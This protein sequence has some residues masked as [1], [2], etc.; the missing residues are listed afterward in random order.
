MEVLY[1]SSITGKKK[2]DSTPASFYTDVAK[3][4]AAEEHGKGTVRIEIPDGYVVYSVGI[5]S[6][7]QVVNE[8]EN[9]LPALYNQGYGEK[10]LTCIIPEKNS[11][12]FYHMTPKGN[13]FVASYGCMGTEKGQLFGERSYVYPISVFWAKYFEKIGKGYVDDSDVYLQSQFANKDNIPLGSRTGHPETASGRLYALLMQLAQN[14]VRNAKVQVPVTAEIISA[15]KRYLEQMRNSGTVEEFNTT[16]LRL[17]AVLQRPVPT[18]DGTG[19][20]KALAKGGSDFPRIIE[21][22]EDL[23]TAMEGTLGAGIS[24]PIGD[25]SDFGIEVYDATEKQKAEALRTL[26]P[27][28]RPKVKNVYRVIPAEQ[29]KLFN[30]Y[31][32]ENGISRVKQL[33]HGSRN[34]NWMSIIRNSLM[35]NQNAVI[36]AKMFGK[37]IYFAPSSMK[38]WGYTSNGK[39]TGLK[40]DVSI[41]GLYAVAYGRQYDVSA[42]RENVDWKR[43]MESRGCS[44]LHAHAGRNLRA[45]EIVV[46]DEAAVVLNYIVEFKC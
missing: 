45:D 28:L 37:G 20:K 22:E 21:R 26:N 25:F 33:W 6:G 9:T 4:I 2:F 44:S 32:K 11:Y 16:L 15:A 27:S 18:G 40:S 8:I 38:S 35:L 46:Y 39:W 43:E 17:M 1:E 14:A 41:M 5:R 30:A 34:E 42:W 13:E 36:T 12:K 19:V 24:Q 23:I 10:Y 7:T 31:L 29:N 3:R